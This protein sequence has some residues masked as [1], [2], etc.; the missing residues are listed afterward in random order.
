M[1]EAFVYKWTNKDNEMYYIGKH[2]GTDTDGYISSGKSFLIEYRK[3]PNNFYREILF[4]G[5]NRECLNMEQS[6][7]RYSISTD[8]YA[9]IYNRT[10]G[11][12]RWLMPSINN[13]IDLKDPRVRKVEREI[14]K[15]L[16]MNT[17]ENNF[18]YTDDIRTL[19]KIRKNILNT[20]KDVLPEP[21]IRTHRWEFISPNGQVFIEKN[22]NQFC[23]QHNLTPNAMSL[24]AQEKQSNHKG[25]KCRKL[26]KNHGL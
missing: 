1:H 10:N 26:D 6:M 3:N 7:I 14:Y 19:R 23:R 5:D 9:K 2:K 22:K 8:G 16:D 11:C 25:W 12:Q 15:L 20:E 4:R 21:R 13:F 18:K 17:K 24:V